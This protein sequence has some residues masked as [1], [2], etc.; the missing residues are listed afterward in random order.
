MP[1][2]LCCCEQ[3]TTVLAVRQPISYGAGGAS[4]VDERDGSFQLVVAGLVEEVAERD[5]SRGFAGEVQGQRRRGS[6]KNTH[7]RIQFLTAILKVGAGDGKVGSVQRSCGQEKDFVF[8]IP[9]FVSGFGNRGSLDERG[10]RNC[11]NVRSWG[12]RERT[13][14]E[15]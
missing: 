1:G 15:R 14:R 2:H 8:S 4:D 6:S 3:Q 5:R 12:L 7:D 13:L 9:E 10:N 11:R